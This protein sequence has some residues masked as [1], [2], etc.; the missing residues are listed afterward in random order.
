[1]LTNPDPIGNKRQQGAELCKGFYLFFTAV[2]KVSNPASTC[3]G[4]EL[5]EDFYLFFSN[6][7]KFRTLDR[8]SVKRRYILIQYVAKKTVF[9]YQLYYGVG[10]YVSSFNAQNFVAIVQV[11]VN[12]ASRKM[13][14]QQLH[15]FICCCLFLH[16]SLQKK[17]QPR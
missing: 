7:I 3:K 12:P 6:V 15:N 9:M 14:P 5:C 10:S 8:L 11:K 13:K 16:I 17:V 4:S 2:D 1:M